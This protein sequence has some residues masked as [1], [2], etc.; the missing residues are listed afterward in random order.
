MPT[1]P[2][3]I[4]PML[5]YATYLGGSS[6]ST[7]ANEGAQGVAVDAQGSVYIVGVTISTDFPTKT[8]VQNVLKGRTDAFI[9]KL[10]ANGQ[11]VYSTY[12]GGNDFDGGAVIKVDDTGA[13]YV[14]GSTNSFDFPT[15]NPIQGAYGL[16]G[17]AFITKLSPTGSQIVYS[18]Y[19]GGA[20][21]EGISDLAIDAQKNVFVIGNIAPALGVPA[22]DFPLVNPIQATHGGGSGDG[23][24]SKI[25]ASGSTLLF[26]T[27]FGGDGDD[28]FQS[29]RYSST[30]DRVYLGYHT[31][32]SNFPPTIAASAV[33]D[34]KPAALGASVAEWLPMRSMGR[35][36]VP[37]R[38]RPRSS[39]PLRNGGSAP[40]VARLRRIRELL[41][42]KTRVRLA[43]VKKGPGLVTFLSPGVR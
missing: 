1:L 21:T 38:S 18:T 22:N 5:S 2:L 25:S 10:D 42:D 6:T 34:L 20:D 23:F 19:L 24:V 8:P 4:D 9:T 39:H 29:I 26:S 11:L 30:D 33:L 36:Q 32:S 14:G 13:A 3:V 7:V 31:D 12:L 41:Q 35:L 17:D 16:R 40:Q 27:Y 37:A 15:V 28:S 43:H